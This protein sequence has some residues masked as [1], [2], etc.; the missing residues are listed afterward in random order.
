MEQLYFDIQFEA[1]RRSRIRSCCRCK[2]RHLCGRPAP[3]IQPA[4]PSLIQLLLVLDAAHEIDEYA[5]RCAYFKAREL[6]GKY[7][8]SE[9]DLK[10]IEQELLL[11]LWSQL[12]HY[13]ARRGKWSTFCNR[14]FKNHIAN[15]IAHR[16]A[17]CRDYRKCIQIG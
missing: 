2:Q 17:A 4:K 10:D 12:R 16:R 6:R 11:R 5:Q 9:E 7:G 1:R 15:L 14:V 8:F 3:P 13:N